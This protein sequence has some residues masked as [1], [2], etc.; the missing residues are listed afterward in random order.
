MKKKSFAFLLFLLP[1]LKTSISSYCKPQ[2]K[3]IDYLAP[4]NI[5]ILANKMFNTMEKIENQNKAHMRKYVRIYQGKYDGQ[6]FWTHFNSLLGLIT[7]SAPRA[8]ACISGIHFPGNSFHKNI[9]PSKTL[10][11]IIC[12]EV[13]HIYLEHIT[14]PNSK[15]NAFIK[16]FEANDLA[17]RTLYKMKFFDSIAKLKGPIFFNKAPYLFNRNQIPYQ[18]GIINGLSN[19]KKTEKNNKQLKKIL[20]KICPSFFHFGALF[21]LFFGTSK[22]ILED[23]K[24]SI[25]YR[26]IIEA[27][28]YFTCYTPCL[29]YSFKS[30]I[31]SRRLFKK[32][33][34]RPI[35]PEEALQIFEKTEKHQLWIEKIFLL[36]IPG[37]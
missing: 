35:S 8:F 7:S 10:T 19:L 36:L 6:V 34:Q 30:S 13:A 32:I 26:K 24:E 18:L 27:S 17:I 1:G 2:Q 22:K 29:F 25:S 15:K 14:I 12:H 9:Q 31:E 37:V 21:A 3:D 11:A 16:E 4:K 5:Q 20:K 28:L 23:L 33:M